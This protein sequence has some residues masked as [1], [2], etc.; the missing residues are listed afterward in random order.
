MPRRPDG[1]LI[2]WLPDMQRPGRFGTPLD[3]TMTVLIQTPAC[4]PV[5]TFMGHARG[6]EP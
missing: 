1:T 4:A 6:S 3:Q 5:G 2:G